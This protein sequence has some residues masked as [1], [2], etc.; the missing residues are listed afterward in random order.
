MPLIMLIFCLCIYVVHLFNLNSLLQILV[1]SPQ[2]I[3]DDVLT[4]VADS[5][6]RHL[7]LLQNRYTPSNI[8]ISS[9][10]AKAW[11]IVRRDNP[12]LRVHIRVESSGAGE[13][14]F[15]PGAPVYSIMYETQKTPVSI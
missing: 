15:Q 5:R 4:L 13:I 6:I 3:D 11:N 12:G 1:I 14:L 7:H 2:N 10:N 9:C 8:C